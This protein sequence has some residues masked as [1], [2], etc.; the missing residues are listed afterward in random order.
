MKEG[1]NNLKERFSIRLDN[2][3]RYGEVRFDSWQMHAKVVDLPTVI[4]AMKSVDLK[5]FYK[6]ADLCQ[7]MVCKME[8]EE[9]PI[10]EESP[11]KNKK[12]DPNKVDK[13][14][15]YPHGI[16]PPLKNVRKRR[17]RKTLKK[18]Y[19][20]APEIEKE[21]KRLLRVDNEAVKVTWEIITEEEDPN[22]PQ[23]KGDD[24][25]STSKAKGKGRSKKESEHMG[26]NETTQGTSREVGL[27][28]IFGAEV[29]DSDEEET[30]M[31][32]IELDETSRLSAD[33]SRLSDSNSMQF[34]GN[35]DKMATEFSQSMFNSSA[36]SPLNMHHD[37]LRGSEGDTYFEGQNS[38]QGGDMSRENRLEELEQELSE[39]RAQQIQKE[40][41]ISSIENQTLRK[42]LQDNLDSLMNR[43]RE[44]EQEINQLQ[45]N[46]Y[47]N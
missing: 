5:S 23:S 38:N 22:K 17:F 13:K 32:M 29:S 14:F 26:D 44:K 7:M 41:E 42:R 21:V 39:L 33:D 19:V 12:K 4:E 40:L 11:N 3:L 20:E 43:I 47:L 1:A 24:E 10:E 16:T 8:P 25:P 46:S 45:A 18:K 36:D 27:Q 2:D 31:K 30:N 9:Q 15:L 35:T 28:D 37:D 6:T 34:Q